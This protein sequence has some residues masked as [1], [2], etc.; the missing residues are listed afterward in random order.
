[1]PRPEKMR[2]ISE[3]PRF[4]SFKPQGVPSKFLQKECLSID[5][6]EAIRLS[7][8]EGLDH[9]AA[10]DRMEISRPTFSRLVMRARAKVA[11]VLVEGHALEIK[12]GQ[13]EF[14]HT[15][16]HCPKCREFFRLCD[17]ELKKPACPSCRSENLV[18]VN[19]EYFG[20]KGNCRRNCISD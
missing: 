16:W 4:F 2:L 18:N 19:Q 14:I 9:Q 12:G 6:Y 8:Y 7:D 1:M 20:Q 17:P 10:S 11:K 5:E 13:Y 15:L 3:P